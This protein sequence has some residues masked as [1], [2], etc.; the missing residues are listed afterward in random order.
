VNGT[1]ADIL[2]KEGE[3][4]RGPKIK[5]IVTNLIWVG[6]ARGGRGE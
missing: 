1:S 2:E 6:K 5:K 4:E 3:R